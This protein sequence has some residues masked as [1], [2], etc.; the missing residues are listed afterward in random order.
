MEAVC[1]EMCDLFNY[2]DAGL[3]VAANIDYV[4]QRK[5]CIPLLQAVL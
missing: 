5:V 1:L 3:L 2:L 4:G